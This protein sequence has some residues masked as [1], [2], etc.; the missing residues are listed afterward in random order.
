MIKSREIKQKYDSM[1]AISLGKVNVENS[2]GMLY[3]ENS[4]FSRLTMFKTIE[5]ISIF[6]NNFWL[7][8]CS[9]PFKKYPNR[10]R[11]DI[12][13]TIKV[14]NNNY[15]QILHSRR[16]QRMYKSGYKLSIDELTSLLRCSYG[17]THKEPIYGLEHQGHFYYRTIPAGGALYPIE[18]Y[19]ISFNSELDKGLYHFDPDTNSLDFIK[20]GDFFDI[21]S[22]YIQAEPNVEM[23]N[24]SGIFITTGMIERLA[25]K[26]G[27]RAYRFMML[28]AGAV[29]AMLSL[30]AEALNLKSCAIGG[31]YDDDLHSFLEIDG[32]FEAVNNVLI[33][34]G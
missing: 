4:K 13:G 27:E 33:I 24:A 6:R 1:D 32:V 18:I 2:L 10:R 34:G 26:Y 23:N 15:T 28:E 3:H 21:L 30:T 17:I 31:Y 14:K 29:N 8:R 12:N 5:K 19:F 16:S 20:G 7:E 22:D 11:I 9:Q 25:V